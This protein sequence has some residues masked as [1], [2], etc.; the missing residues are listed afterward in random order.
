MDTAIGKLNLIVHEKGEWHNKA[1]T[2]PI[3]ETIGG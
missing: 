3:N 1:S 2:K